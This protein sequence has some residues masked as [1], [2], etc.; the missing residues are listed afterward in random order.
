MAVCT[1]TIASRALSRE[2][3]C[4]KIGAEFVV[5]TYPCNDRW[6][7]G[8]DAAAPSAAEDR[9][10]GPDHRQEQD[11]EGHVA[12]S[13]GTVTRLAGLVGGAQGSDR[14]VAQPRPVRRGR[15]QAHDDQHDEGYRKQQNGEEQEIDLRQAP[16][17]GP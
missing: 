17:P 4:R 6:R 11:A 1:A 9:P 15:G 12:T 10:D 14:E 16:R 5:P 7:P 2:A 8:V 13:R 3:A